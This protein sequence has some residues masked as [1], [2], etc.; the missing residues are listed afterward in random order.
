MA[1][2]ESDAQSGV[3]RRGGLTLRLRLT[4]LYG[5]VFLAAG[6]GL[7][8]ITYGLFKHNQTSSVGNLAIRGVQFSLRGGQVYDACRSGEAG[9]SDIL[10]G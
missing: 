4:L 6:A 9:S 5:S 3:R 2:T 10:R 1:D 8:A 7:L